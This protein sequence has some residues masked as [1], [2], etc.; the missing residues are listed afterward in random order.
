[1]PTVLRIDG[2]EIMIYL[3]DHFPAHVHVFIGGNEAVIDLNCRKVDPEI[4]D[5]Y[6]LKPRQTR[7]ALA[8][9]TEH[10]DLLCEMW[11]QIHGNV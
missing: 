7:S 4:R 10:R 1:M 11:E 8:I 5:V 9:V 2:Y 6:R 3:H